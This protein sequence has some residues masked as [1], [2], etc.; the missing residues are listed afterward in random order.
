MYVYSG[1]G[2]G[3]TGGENGKARRSNTIALVCSS[4]TA[5][6]EFDVG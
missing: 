6:Y 1:S 5:N 2:D 4:A 3:Y